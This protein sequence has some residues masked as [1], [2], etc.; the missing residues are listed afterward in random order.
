MNHQMQQARNIGL[1]TLRGRGFVRR[2]L[3]V[4]GQFSSLFTGFKGK[5]GAI[6]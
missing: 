6:S 1:E 2:G 5:R 4:G 3:G